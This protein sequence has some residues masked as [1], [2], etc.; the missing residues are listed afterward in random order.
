MH[1]RFNDLIM[2]VSKDYDLVLIDTPPILAVTDA[3]IIGESAGTALMVAKFELN[4][5]REVEVSVKRF[6]QNGIEIKGVVINAV[7]RRAAN[8]YN[9]NYDYKY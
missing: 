7:I 3:A 4:T 8:L 2:D 5:P 9:Y 6:L 1:H